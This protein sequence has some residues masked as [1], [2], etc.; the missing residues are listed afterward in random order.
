MPF[1]RTAIEETRHI[2]VDEIFIKRDVQNLLKKLI[3]RDMEKMF[4]KTVKPRMERVHYALMTDEGI[5]QVNSGMLLIR[6]SNVA[7]DF[8]EDYF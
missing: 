5:K 4:A 7:L 1:S 8:L 3:G 6:L 2:N